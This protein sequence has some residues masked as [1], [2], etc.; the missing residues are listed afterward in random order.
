M[1]TDHLQARF[2]SLVD[3][4][5]K[6]VYKIASSY[7]ASRDDRDDLAQ[8]IVTQ[9]WRSFGGFDERVR[10]STWFYRVALNVAISFA[11]REHR[12]TRH[13]VLDDAYLLEAPEETQG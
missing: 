2:V 7:C 4:H 9:A 11:R 13:V 12:R 6:I 5:R 10:F 1:S 3:E 8:E